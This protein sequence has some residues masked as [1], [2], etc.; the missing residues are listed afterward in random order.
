MHVIRGCAGH[1]ADYELAHCVQVRPTFVE[2]SIH[3]RL[4]GGS[5]R[6]HFLLS[7]RSSLAAVARA[8]LDRKKRLHVGAQ[9]C[10]LPLSCQTL[11]CSLAQPVRD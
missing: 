7:Y 4:Y 5:V 1:H 10:Q 9:S 3:N 8:Q 11:C 2:M 6:Q